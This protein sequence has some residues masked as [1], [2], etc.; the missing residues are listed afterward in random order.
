MFEVW[1]EV[2]GGVGWDCWG[3]WG[4]SVRGVIEIRIIVRSIY[5]TMLRDSAH[6]KDRKIA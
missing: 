6:S 5:S 2:G 1:G 3:E 4:W